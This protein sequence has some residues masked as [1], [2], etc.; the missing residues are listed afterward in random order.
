MSGDG[1]ALGDGWRER[2]GKRE[3]LAFVAEMWRIRYT[4]GKLG[5]IL[6]LYD[7]I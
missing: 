3:C 7:G 2:G 4:L 1:P 5:G 6:I